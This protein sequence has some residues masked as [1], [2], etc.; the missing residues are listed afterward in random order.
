[1][2]ELVVEA[3][4]WL[5]DRTLIELRLAEEG[6][7]VLG[8]EKAGGAYLGAPRG[9]SRVEPSDTLYLYG[10]ARQIAELDRHRDDARG[11]WHP[12][13]AVDEQLRVEAAESDMRRGQSPRSRVTRIRMSFAIQWLRTKRATGADGMRSIDDCRPLKKRAWAT[14]TRFRSSR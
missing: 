1:M 13:R 8:V 5:A 7:L 14:N 6:I 9:Q 4:D 12:H 11:N 3:E 10:S 2:S